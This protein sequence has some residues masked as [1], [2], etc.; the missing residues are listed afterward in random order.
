MEITEDKDKL[1]RAL[2][3]FR[4][5]LIEDTI[6]YILS[7]G[8]TP[9]IIVL[10]SAIMHGGPTRENAEVLVETFNVSPI[11]V[12]D[13]CIDKNTIEFDAQFSGINNRVVVDILGVF[14][15]FSQENPSLNSIKIPAI[16][17]SKQ[18]EEVASKNSYTS[19][20]VKGEEKSLPSYLKVIK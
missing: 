19:K 17:T 20:R 13:L 10:A 5:Q 14:S 16:G 9:H 4:E 8:E 12:H 15:V 2:R 18:K 1:F 11:A 3:K 7:V 6:E